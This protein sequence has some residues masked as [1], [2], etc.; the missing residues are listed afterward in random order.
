MTSWMRPKSSP[1]PAVYAAPVTVMEYISP[2]LEVFAATVPV[3]ENFSPAPASSYAETER[4][5]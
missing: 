4:V 2:A 1:A 5:P 3:V